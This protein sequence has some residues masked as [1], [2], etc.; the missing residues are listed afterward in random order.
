MAWFEPFPA[1]ILLCQ[2]RIGGTRE[3]AFSSRVGRLRSAQRTWPTCVPSSTRSGTVTAALRVRRLRRRYTV[4][5]PMPLRPRLRRRRDSGVPHDLPEAWTDQDHRLVREVGLAH[6][7]RMLLGP[8]RQPPA[9]PLDRLRHVWD[10]PEL[11]VDRPARVPRR[12][13]RAASELGRAPVPRYDLASQQ[14]RQARPVD[15]A[16]DDVDVPDATLA[17]QAVL[18]CALG[19]RDDDRSFAPAEQA[20]IAGEERI[21]IGVGYSPEPL[22]VGVVNRLVRAGRG[23]L[24]LASPRSRADATRPDEQRGGSSRKPS[25]SAPASRRPGA[26]PAGRRSR[27]A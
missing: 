10:H 14:A 21:K 1:E 19:E 11:H 3:A 15:E 9:Q 17:A 25:G 23:A 13:V 4:R 24:R 22:E 20:R 6:R 8:S 16:D 7:V 12:V 26:R 18:G 27:R 5:P 2:A